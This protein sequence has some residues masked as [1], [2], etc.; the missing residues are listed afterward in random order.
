MIEIS[1]KKLID[2]L[3]YT[4]LRETHQSTTQGVPGSPDPLGLDL[5]RHS[6]EFDTNRHTIT[7]KIL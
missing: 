6:I 2:E 3:K 7:P 5:E 4:G 1:G